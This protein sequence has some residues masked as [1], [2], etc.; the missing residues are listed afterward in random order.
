MIAAD[1]F[2]AEAPIGQEPHVAHGLDQCWTE[3]GHADHGTTSSAV[4]S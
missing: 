1:A 4:P 3:V 2:A